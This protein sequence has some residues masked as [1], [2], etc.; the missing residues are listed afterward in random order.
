[1][2]PL[3]QNLFTL[4]IKRSESGDANA[5]DLVDTQDALHYQKRPIPPAAAGDPGP[6]GPPLYDIWDPLSNS[7]LSTMHAVPA[8]EKKKRTILLHNPTVEVVMTFSGK[9]NFRWQFT[10][11][12]HT[13]EFKRDELFLLRHPD[14]PVLVTVF[15]FERKRDKIDLGLV[16]LMDYNL[17][18]FDIDDRK[19]LEVVIITGLLSFQD[20][21]TGTTV[22]SDSAAVTSAATAGTG[23]LSRLA[24]FNASSGSGGNTSGVTSPTVQSP[25]QL[26][27]GLQMRE[28][29]QP[30]EILVTSLFDANDYAEYAVKL[31]NDPNLLYIIIRSQTEEEVSKVVTIASLAKRM[32]YKGGAHEEELHQ[33]VRYDEREQPGSKGPKVIKLDGPAGKEPTKEYRPPTALIIHLSK[34][35]MPELQPAPKQPERPSVA[36]HSRASLQVNDSQTSK[37][38]QGRSKSAQRESEPRHPPRRDADSGGS[39]GKSKLHKEPDRRP[40]RGTSPMPPQTGAL[41]TSTAGSSSRRG[42]VASESSAPGPISPRTAF[43]GFFSPGHVVNTGGGQSHSRPPPAGSYQSMPLSPS[44]RIPGSFPSSYFPQP[45][46]P[47][48]P[49]PPQQQNSGLSSFV[50]GLLPQGQQ[51]YERFTRK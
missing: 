34:I 44:E 3:D 15:D 40:G 48:P 17:T 49:T 50:G 21:V 32:R 39:N 27:A 36:G 43:Q 5:L 46:P 47:K 13:F 35:P 11:E 41:N 33:Y 29:S 25:G 23:M 20:Q 1:M 4:K 6:E 30:N 24:T 45:E 31:L 2:P 26:V 16:Q 18:R 10:W 38:R 7:L 9:I 22:A 51:L 12:D 37:G 19:G 42:R 14:P 28:K 8:T